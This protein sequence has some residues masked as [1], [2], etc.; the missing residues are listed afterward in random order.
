MS[1]SS[2]LSKCAAEPA[3]EVGRSVASPRAKTFGFARRL[4]RV[5]VGRDEAERVAEAG[6][7]V[8]EG[9]AAVERNGDEQVEGELAAV[10]GDEPA[11]GAVDLAGAE[12][13]LDL[14]LLL[15]EQMRQVLRRRSAW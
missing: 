4:E 7:A 14:D 5:R 13:D 3:F 9:C 15:V 2:S 8:D 12:L 1:P 11:A 10:V 6:R